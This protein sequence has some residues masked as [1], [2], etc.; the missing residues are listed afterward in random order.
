[1]QW[2]RIFEDFLRTLCEIRESAKKMDGQLIRNTKALALLSAGNTTSCPH[3]IWIDPSEGDRDWR[4]WTI[5]RMGKKA[6]KLYFVCEHSFS[7]VEPALVFRV[8]REWVEMIAP[9][10]KMCVFLLRVA[11]ATGQLTTLLPLPVLGGFSDNILQQLDAVDAFATKYLDP[12][13]LKELVEWDRSHTDIQ[14]V[15][16]KRITEVVG[17]A[18]KAL[19]EKANKEKHSEWKK[20]L[21]PV[22]NKSGVTIYV[23]NE[24]MTNLRFI[25]FVLVRGVACF[26]SWAYCW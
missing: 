23:K 25:C 19:E 8:T 11:L 22:L 6:V 12:D 18:Y 24:Y 21:K 17:E 4:N 10:L 26:I 13:T 9:A 7:V 3:L 1:M 14:D 15:I 5:P 2:N 16:Y 20:A